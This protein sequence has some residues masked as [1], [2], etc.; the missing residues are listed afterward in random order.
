MEC[1]NTPLDVSFSNLY[2]T[3]RS[4]TCNEN[5]IL[6]FTYEKNET[7]MLLGGGVWES[8]RANPELTKEL[9]IIF[10]DYFISRLD[11]T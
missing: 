6:R 11:L 2:L 3:A 4:V 10:C 8:I 9:E 1:A 7:T 5:L